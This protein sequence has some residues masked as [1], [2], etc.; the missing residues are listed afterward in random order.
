VPVKP[1]ECVEIRIYRERRLIATLHTDKEGRASVRLEQGYYKF[2]YWKNGK[3]IGE[4]EKYV[5]RPTNIHFFQYFKYPPPPEVEC[6]IIPSISLTKEVNPFSSVSMPMEAFTSLAFELALIAP[7]LDLI[8]TYTVP[9]DLTDITFSGLDISTHKFYLLIIKWINPLTSLMNMQAYF[10]GDFE[11]VRYYTQRFVGS[12]TT[13]SASR[14][15]AP[16]IAEAGAQQSVLVLTF[17]QRDQNGYIRGQSKTCFGVGRGIEVRHYNEV[18]TISV[19]NLTRINISTKGYEAR[20]AGTVI[21]RYGM[22]TGG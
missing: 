16:Q 20:G 14:I 11:D 19:A 2:E 3:K 4:T 7:Q 5:N 13:I 12:G 9:I 18:Y 17:I 22:K 10:Q 6:V 1:V 8:K 21:D 15:N